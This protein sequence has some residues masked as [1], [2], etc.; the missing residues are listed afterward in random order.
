MPLTIGSGNSN[1]GG[2]SQSTGIYIVDVYDTSQDLTFFI[3]LVDNPSSY[4]GVVVYVKILEQ[5]SG[6]D[7]WPDP[8]LF[9][10]KFYFNEDGEWYESPFSFNGVILE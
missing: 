3:D 5:V 4:K 6:R 8:F 10:N 7:P 9:P 2:G 1:D